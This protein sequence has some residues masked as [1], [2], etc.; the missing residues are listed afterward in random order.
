MLSLLLTS[1]VLAVLGCASSKSGDEISKERAIEIARQQIHFEPKSTEAVPVTDQG[2]AVW[3]VTFRGEDL[4]PTNP[5]GQ[6]QIFEIDRH[7]GEIV[8]L[9]MS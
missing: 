2:R 8:S 4:S 6:V 7:T 3:R 1:L 5:I 9:A